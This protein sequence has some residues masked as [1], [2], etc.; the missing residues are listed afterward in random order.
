MMLKQ[1]FELK[2]KKSVVV[3]VDMATVYYTDCKT[4]PKVA[5]QASCQV[6]SFII[7]EFLTNGSQLGASHASYK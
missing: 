5:A 3:L 7:N 1:D 4:A 6:Q 2:Q